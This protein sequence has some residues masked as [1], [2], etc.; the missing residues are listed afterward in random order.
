MKNQMIQKIPIGYKQTEIGVIPE[1]WNILRLNETSKVIDSLHQTPNFVED[2]FA[3]V[4]V[5][6]IKSGT[7]NLE[8]ALRVDEKVF[9]EFIRNYQP[10]QG[11]IVL[12]RV[13]SYGI[14]SFVNTNEF[15]CMG[16]NTVVIVPNVDN[17]YLYYV[18]NST[19]IRKQ[20]EEGSFGSGY[21]S[22][23]LKNIK[24]LKLQLP[25]NKFEQSA[26][27]TVLSDT[28]ALIEK[29]EKLIAKKKDI[30]QGAMQQLLTG[31]KRLPG[32]SGEWKVK[33]LG[34]VAEM[35]SGG[36][37]LT[38]NN[39][40]YGGQIPWVV[41]ADMTRIEKYLFNTEKNITELG[42]KNSSAKLFKKGTLLFAMYA[43]IGKCAIAKIDIT[44]NQA[45]L[46][47]NTKKIDTEFLYYYLAFN[48]QKYLQM[49]QAGAQNNLNKEIV[50]N[51]DIPY[52]YIEEQTA[53]ATV[54]SDMDSEIEKLEQKKDKYIMLKQGM[55]QQ[56]L[57]GRIRI[58]D[59]KKSKCRTNR[60]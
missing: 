53:I 36:T 16:Q 25:K 37:P 51:L 30:K 45:I 50:Q 47:I 15:F 11:D 59:N 57:T 2:G 58:Y 4:R 13:G 22:L 26:I 55:M 38:S 49:G 60:T 21:K 9:L 8:G 34:E 27:A 18:L 32:F 1:D 14:S 39:S 44:S 5:A 28:D 6:D 17:K 33:K 52:P 10:K 43:S 24:E 40:Y 46:G 48:E 56:L 3:M 20:I 54:L 35:F 19:I 29:L 23:S 42:L 41:I 7:L 31:K 12:S